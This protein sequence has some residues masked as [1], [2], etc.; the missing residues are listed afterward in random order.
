MAVET[1]GST[2]EQSIIWLLSFPSVAILANAAANAV[3][4]LSWLSGVR[5]IH[6]QKIRLET[7]RGMGGYALTKDCHS[8]AVRES[9][10]NSKSDC[11]RI[12]PA[13]GDITSPM[14]PEVLWCGCQR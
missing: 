13:I 9:W 14:L 7:R 5:R 2:S 4:I 3:F 8:Q 6:G 12:S 10:A 1:R 11:K